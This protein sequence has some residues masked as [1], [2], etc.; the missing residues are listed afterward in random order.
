MVVINDSWRLAPWADALYA[1]DGPWWR[2]HAE[3]LAFGGLKITQDCEAA[4]AYGLHLVHV[5]PAARA[6]LLDKPGVL[7]GGENGGFQAINFALQAGAR[8]IGLVGFDMT[9]ALGVHWHG[10]HGR[11]LNNPDADL[12]ERWRATLDAQAEPLGEIGATVL[13]LSPASALTAFRKASLEDVLWPACASTAL[14]SSPL[15][16]TAAPR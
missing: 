6:F 16:K 9:L 15:T 10:P 3:A 7:G 8:R 13:N 5:D 14:T 4:S 1:C 11:G 12:V 2:A